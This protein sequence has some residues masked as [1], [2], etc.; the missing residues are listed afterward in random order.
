MI[1]FPEDSESE[2][3]L[4]RAVTQGDKQSKGHVTNY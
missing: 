2:R 3:A 1:E 4:A